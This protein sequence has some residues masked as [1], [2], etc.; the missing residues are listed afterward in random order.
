MRTKTRGQ[1]GMRFFGSLSHHSFS[2]LREEEKE[3]EEVRTDENDDRISQRDF[4][5]LDRSKTFSS[6]LLLW[7]H[8]FH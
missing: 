7:G 1:R 3:E 5:A 8:S 4:S 6:I 2:N